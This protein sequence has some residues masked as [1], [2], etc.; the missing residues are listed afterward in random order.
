MPGED[1]I[2][3][4]RP[5]AR[6]RA[7]TMA[8]TSHPSVQNDFEADLGTFAPT[9]EIDPVALRLTEGG[10]S[11]AGYCLAITNTVPGGTFGTRIVPDKL[12]LTSLPQLSFDYK[13]PADGTAKTSLYLTIDGE[14]CEI[15]FSGPPQGT[16][17]AKRLGAIAGVIATAVAPRA[18]RPAQRGSRALRPVGR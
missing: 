12:D 9:S 11:G 6:D 16:P 13:L 8:S 3:P 18:F 7:F 15:V 1:A 14:L 2:L 4:P 5:R 10:P 17:L